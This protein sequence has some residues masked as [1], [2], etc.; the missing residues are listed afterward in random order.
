MSNEKTLT[1][2]GF[3]L[4]RKDKLAYLG[5]MADSH[6]I[7]L[8]ILETKDVQ[9]AEVATKVS[10]ELQLTDPSVRAKDR[11]VKKSEKD[12]FYTALDVGCVWLKRALS[13]K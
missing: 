13:Q 11:I 8:Q 1:Y 10:V 4:M 3:P 7:L 12:G 9:G 5:S 6:I 2:Q